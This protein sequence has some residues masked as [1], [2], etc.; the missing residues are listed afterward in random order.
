MP[1]AAGQGSTQ[2]PVANVPGRLAIKTE[3]TKDQEPDSAVRS[4]YA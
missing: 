4:L 1:G 2:T 3:H